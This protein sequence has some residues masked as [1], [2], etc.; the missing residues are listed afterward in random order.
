MHQLSN[1][2]FCNIV[3]FIEIRIHSFHS[4][5]SHLLKLRMQVSLKCCLSRVVGLIEALW[6]VLQNMFFKVGL[7]DGIKQLQFYA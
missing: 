5:V 3:R 7:L 6:T 4:K 2:K 1:I